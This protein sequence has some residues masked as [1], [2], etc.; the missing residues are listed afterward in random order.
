M[1]GLDPTADTIRHKQSHDTNKEYGHASHCVCRWGRGSGT[2]GPL[3]TPVPMVGGPSPRAG[4]RAQED[5]T[6]TGAAEAK[7]S[8]RTGGL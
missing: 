2:H 6:D 4:E 7:A 8:K 3:G 1:G 5:R